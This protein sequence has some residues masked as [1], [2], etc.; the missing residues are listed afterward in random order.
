MK[1]VRVPIAHKV[2]MKSRRRRRTK[3]TTGG[4]SHEIPHPTILLYHLEVIEVGVNC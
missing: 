2:G 1:K 4:L 3:V